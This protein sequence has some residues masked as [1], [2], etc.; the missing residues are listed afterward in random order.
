MQAEIDARKAAEEKLI[1][2]IESE[3]APAET[4]ATETP[5]VLEK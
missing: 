5:E 1:E 3:E 4:A 2:E